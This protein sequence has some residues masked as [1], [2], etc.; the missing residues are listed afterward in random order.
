MV[1]VWAKASETSGASWARAAAGAFWATPG[2]RCR[3]PRRRR[4]PVGELVGEYDRQAAPCRSRHRERAGGCS[5][6]SSRGRSHRGRA[7]GRPPTSPASSSSPGRCRA[8]TSAA[9]SQNVGS[10]PTRA[11]TPSPQHEHEPGR[12]DRLGAVA[13]GDPPGDRH[14]D[15]RAEPLRTSAGRPPAPPR[16]APPGSTAGS[17]SSPRRAPRRAGHL[18]RGEAVNRGS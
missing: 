12:D 1:K 11:K 8:R 14:R 13:V 15:R 16:R 18:M 3:H 4:Q 2:A 7:P 10:T 17:G 9:S 5:S 6:P